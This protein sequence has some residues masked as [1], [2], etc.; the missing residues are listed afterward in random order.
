VNRLADGILRYWYSDGAPG[1]LAKSISGIAARLVSFRRAKSRD[2]SRSLLGVP[3]VVVGNITVGGT[4]K[5]PLITHL[6]EELSNRGFKVG[7][8]SRGHGGSGPFPCTVQSDTGPSVCG[9]EPLLL[10]RRCRVPVVVDPDRLTACRTLVDQF[11]PDVILSDDGL[12]HYRMPRQLEIVVFDGCRGVGNGLMLP[13]GPLRE[14]V[15]RLAHVDAVVVNGVASASLAALLNTSVSVPMFD[16]GIRSGQWRD[17]RGQLR[18]GSPG[19]DRRVVAV[20]GIGNPER[21]F[22]TLSGLGVTFDTR[23]YADHHHYVRQDV[24]DLIDVDV[25]TTEKDAVKMHPEWLPHVW[26]LPVRAETKPSLAS[27]IADRLL[28]EM[29]KNLEF[30]D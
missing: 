9:D 19:K 10:A 2:V 27:F 17:L 25:V 5:T 14:A 28:G 6:V 13:F 21:F 15:D 29:P 1:V 7:V 12:Q 23:I 24:M 26:V 8:V 18:S 30:T 20:A 3:V 11:E 4:G 16:M 22:S